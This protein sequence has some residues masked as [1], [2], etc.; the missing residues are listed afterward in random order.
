MYSLENN[1][2]WT[3]DLKNAFKHNVTK[4]KIL[5]TGTEIN[6]DNYLKDVTLDEQYYIQNYGFVGVAAAKKVEI[7]LIDVNRDINLENQE[8]TLKIGAEYNNND[9]YINY[10]NFIVDKPPEHDETNGQTRVVAY[11]YMIKFNKPY[12]NRVTYPCSLLTLL[13]DVCSQAEVTLGSTDFANKTFTV[14][15]NQF[16]G[17]TLRE[18]LQNIAKC[19]FSWARIGQDN[20]LY[21]DF[22]VT[23]TTTE[24]ITID[25]YQLNSFKKAHEYYGPVNQVTYA[26]SD[27][28]GQEERVKDQQSID[29][30]GLKELVIYDNLFAYTAEK[31]SELIQAGTRL[32]GLTYMPITQL[33]L[34]GFAYLD[35]RDAI[36]V[37]NLDEET[38]SSRIFS[39]QIRY[40]GTLHDSIVTEG[41]SDN[42]EIYKNTATNVF[43]NQQTQ[44]KVD[45]ANKKIQLM[46]QEIDEQSNKIAELE[47]TTDEI[48][49]QVSNIYNAT[50]T[51]RGNKEI[52]LEKC[53][54]GYL[55]RLR[56]IG[57]N[58][59]FSRLYPADDLYPADTLYPKGD[60]RIVVTDNDGN[61]MIYDLRVSE[62][63]RAN[64]EVYDEYIL[65]SNYAK[66][67][68]RV[69]PD[70]TTKAVEEIEDIGVYTI[71]VSQDTNT[72]EIQNYNAVIEA[73]Y[74]EQNGYT[75]Q[76]ATVI[77]MNSSIE[78]AEQ[79][80][81]IELNK[82]VDDETLTGANIMLR[83]NGDESEA[84]INADKIALTAGDVLNVIAG[85]SIDLSSNNITINSDNFNVDEEGNVTC[86]SLELTG[87]TI[88]GSKIDL[89]I[90]NTAGVD[91]FQLNAPTHNA[92]VLFC[93]R[94][95][96]W[97]KVDKW[98]PMVDI[99]VMSDTDEGYIDCDGTVT[100]VNVVQTSK[101]SLKKNI[102]SY[103]ENALDIIKQSRIYKYNFK[104]ENDTDKK[105]I[106]FVIPDEGGDYKTPNEV[107]S[108]NQ[109]GIDTYTMTSILWKAVQEQ[110]EIIEKLKE[111]IKNIKEGKIDD[112]N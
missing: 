14:Q 57:N 96:E 33:D 76:F 24:T 44:I 54:Q 67:I 46:T 89:N 6:Q 40:T 15:D 106:G 81:N 7:N 3:D 110:Q 63:L 88:T 74:V 29:E 101:E 82:K 105:H 64:E 71:Y 70:G 80:I 39:H 35:C 45:K 41:S 98:T 99:G 38:F 73:T 107:I 84:T 102:T 77:E 31:R 108:S 43:Q 9:Y 92:Y 85:N 36:A 94:N 79:E 13:Q 17:Y 11:D 10:G 26:D 61:E 22:N 47:I 62:V 69:N 55:I 93:G 23:P 42:E 48:E 2:Q 65:E 97:K 50:K 30:N 1:V 34:I 49:A 90:E 75:D 100:C 104:T 52:T 37:E 8:V 19:A 112:K 66:V 72:I 20:K 4:A 56:I 83:I 12:L 58:D 111:E 95:T 32:F 28:E 91:V 53:V 18:V 51:V 25:E 103:N 16:E 109:K 5:W 27:I 78:L 21:L 87:G 59:V 68:R 86:S 60:S